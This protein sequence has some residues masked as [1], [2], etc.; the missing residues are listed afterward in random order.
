MRSA[1]VLSACMPRLVPHKKHLEKA[2]TRDMQVLFFANA[3]YMLT[4][5]IGHQHRQFTG[6]KKSKNDESQKRIYECSNA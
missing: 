5:H 4:Q 3:A 2:L 6:G 1:D